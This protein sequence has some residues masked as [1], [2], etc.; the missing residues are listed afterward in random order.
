MRKFG[1]FYFWVIIFLEKFKRI[2]LLFLND[3]EIFLDYFVYLYIFYL[4]KNV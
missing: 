2:L 3:L 4:R 1:H